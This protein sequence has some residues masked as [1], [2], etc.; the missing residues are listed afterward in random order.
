MRRDIK[1]QLQNL[2]NKVEA[3][4]PKTGHFSKWKIERIF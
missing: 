3:M 2:E 1:I 4:S